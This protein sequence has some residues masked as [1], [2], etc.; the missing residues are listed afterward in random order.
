VKKRLTGIRR[1]MLTGDSRKRVR[2]YLKEVPVVKTIDKLAFTLGVGLFAFIEYMMLEKSEYFGMFYVGIM[3]PLLIVRYFVFSK[4]KLQYFLLDLCYMVA[5]TSMVTVLF[6]AYIG[7]S[8]FIIA[9]VL[10]NG[11]LVQLIFLFLCFCVCVCL[12]FACI[13]VFFFHFFFFNSSLFIS[14]VLFSS[15]LFSSLTFSTLFSF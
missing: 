8:V 10:G 12:M 3:V 2:D 1:K 5:A 9:F 15:L 13:L 6:P 14:S 4:D 11:V 7:R